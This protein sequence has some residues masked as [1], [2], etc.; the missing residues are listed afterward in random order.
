MRIALVLLAA[1]AT[2]PPGA[3]APVAGTP[4]APAEA[5]EPA[6]TLTLFAIPPPLA[7]DWSTPNQ[8]LSSV[9][10][11][12]S[13]ATD[14]VKA[15]DAAMTHSI[16]HV[17]VQLDCGDLSIPLTGQTDTGGS[18]DWQAGTDG[19]GL[20]LRD[21]PGALDAMAD[22]GDPADTAADIA[23]REASGH[24]TRVSFRVNRAM[25]Q[26][27]KSFVDEYVA[28]GAYHHYDGAARARR[29]E[30][31]GC[32]IFGA[33]VVDVG[34][35]LRRSLMT[36]AWARTEMIGSARIGDFLGAGHY[37]YGGN[38]VA[39]DDAGT[40]WVWPQGVD[41]PASATSPVVIYSRVLD[42]WHGPEDAP[43]DVPGLT[44][45]MQ[46]QLPFTIY[47]PEMIAEWA[48]GVWLDATDHG[49][50]TALGVPWTA[51]TV[52]SVHEITYDASC[53]QPQTIAFDGDAD[54]LFADSAQ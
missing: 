13:A 30:G 33:G 11:S 6:G 54:D 12:R 39:V 35:L 24:L 53:V 48:E 34:G 44:G 26:R 29:F 5:C 45:A 25:C 18:E 8:L 50:A 7:L 10:A 21:T 14:L 41:V 2:T 20:L 37:R 1:C 52:E 28:R 4:T 3:P 49:T 32:A 47:D 46:T 38:L 15:G 19:A 27:L 23:A 36:P 43:F 16:G 42:A 9:I 17:N 51:G 40:H 22:I 31:A